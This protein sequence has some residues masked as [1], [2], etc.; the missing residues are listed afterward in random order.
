VVQVGV[1]PY[2][3]ALAALLATQ[4]GVTPSINMRVTARSWD[5]HGDLSNSMEAILLGS[6]RDTDM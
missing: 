4:K 6:E 1:E 5:V 2:C 3:I